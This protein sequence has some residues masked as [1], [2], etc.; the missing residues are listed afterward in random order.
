MHVDIYLL[1]ELKN[2]LLGTAVCLSNN[3]NDV[4]LRIKV[5]IK[6]RLSEHVVL[7]I[8]TGIKDQTGDFL[9]SAVILTLF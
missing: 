5:H 2:L 7:P 3:W 1:F 9:H 8:V 6:E 4:H